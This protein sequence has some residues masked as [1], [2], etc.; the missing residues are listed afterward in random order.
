M[1]GTKI[2]NDPA[3]AKAIGAV[4]ALF[5]RERIGLELGFYFDNT[6]FDPL[7]L[8][9]PE[10]V[11]I[12]FHYQQVTIADLPLIEPL[13]RREV[14]RAKALGGAYGIIH[15]NDY[16]IADDLRRDLP[17]YLGK[18]EQAEA[19]AERHDFPMYIENVQHALPYY[20]ALFEA[21]AERRLTHLH[22][23]FDLG[24][25]KALSAS[26]REHSASDWLSCL[27]RLR[28]KGFK[29]HFHL[30]NNSGADDEHLSFVESERLGFNGPDRFSGPLGYLG[31]LARIC[32][33][34]EAERKIFEVK[35]E[36]A[37]ANLDFVRERLGSLGG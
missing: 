1:F 34:F 2:V 18:L 7:Q 6:L 37:I 22:C 26:R 20:E 17:S 5:E 10:R 15:L 16:T 14:G 3:T 13:I 32:G 25:A 9:A 11:N 28:N 23:C 29:I 35:M 27:H 21:I 19:I 4:L 12:H 33:E 31:L 24:H 36:L 30:H 8:D